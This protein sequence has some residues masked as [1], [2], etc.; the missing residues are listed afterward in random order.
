VLFQVRRLYMGLN[1]DKSD[2]VITLI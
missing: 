1:G 2:N